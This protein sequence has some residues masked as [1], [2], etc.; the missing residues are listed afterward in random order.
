[1]TPD[2]EERLRAL[3]A[4]DVDPALAARVR[5]RAHAILRERREA[6]SP[7]SP[8]WLTTY[9][10]FV[11]PALLVALGFTYLAWTVTD[12]VALFQ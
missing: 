8:G 4:H 7:P 11:E 6:T 1:M 9:H 2:D 12:T 5:A 3:P 10:R